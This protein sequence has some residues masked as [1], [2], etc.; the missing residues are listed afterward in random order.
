MRA[1]EANAVRKTDRQE[2]TIMHLQRIFVATLMMLATAAP[3]WSQ[4]T[5]QTTFAG[6]LDFDGNIFDIVA[7]SP[8]EVTGFDVNLSP[9]SWDLEVYTVTA[10]GS[11]NGLETNAAAWTLAASFPSVVSAGIGNPTALPAGLSVNMN[12][13]ET[14]GFYVT[15]TGGEGINYTTG[16]AIGAV[17]AS[18]IHV[19][20]LEGF[21]LGYPFGQNFSPRV[22][23][24][25]LRYNLR[26]S[27]GPD[28]LVAALE[29]PV[30]SAA[31]ACTPLSASE[32][33][34]V[35]VTNIGSGPLGA[36][37]QFDLSITLDD[38][39]AP[40]T[41]VMETVTLAA[42]LPAFASLS[43]P[44]VATLDLSTPG[45]YQV[46]VEVDLAGD[47]EPT[48]DTLSLALDSGAATISSLPYLE[49][50]ESGDGVSAPAGWGQ[51]PNDATGD[52]S[53]WLFISG[54]TPSFNI[55]PAGDHSSGLGVYA[56]VEDSFGGNHETVNLLS[57]CFDLRAAPSAALEFWCHSTD[58]DGGVNANTMHVDVLLADGT[59]VLDVIPAIGHVP[60]NDWFRISFDLAPFQNQIFNIRFR[61]DSRNGGNNTFTHD[62]AIDDFRIFEVIIQDGQVPQPGL[63][64]MDI[65]NALDPN[66]D[67]VES[68]R[69]GPYFNTLFSGATMTIEVSG[70]TNR[71]V[72]LLT[73]P[74]NVNHSNFG[75]P[76]RL[77]IGTAG[78]PLPGNLLILSDG[79]SMT[80]LFPQLAQTGASGT[81]V[82]GLS[83]NLPAGLVIPFQAVV[84]NNSA[85]VAALSN[86]VVVTVF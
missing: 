27:A 23:N 77:D 29:A 71:P 9:G 51:D 42:P 48:N 16:T 32:A 66:G 25:N 24:C 35:R 22:F 18:D 26:A 58:R 85:A 37:T 17:A 12:P 62:I 57:P 7:S 65:N 64:V 74:L 76:G 75:V 5:V 45:S 72:V 67:P 10:G 82:F 70:P 31:G 28:L 63:A 43:H 30:G 52:N 3:A 84:T 41:V 21:G 44:F 34:S 61:G 78:S 50:F 56:Y 69:P 68:G 11:M 81:M 55:G 47:V 33:A 73:G 80:G 46:D 13:G 8:I 40:P 39:M 86:A 54:L 49:D 79:I 20:L 36:G 53:D 60:G 4:Q 83:L 15:T 38:G 59:I 2:T 6:G 1:P 19:A 14:L